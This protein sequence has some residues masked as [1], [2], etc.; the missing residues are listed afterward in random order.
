MVEE[1]GISLPPQAG[2]LRHWEVK[3]PKKLPDG[4]SG[5]LPQGI[6]TALC[7][8]TYVEALW[9]DTDGRL[10]LLPPT[11]GMLCPS[12][13]N[14]SSDLNPTGTK[15]SFSLALH[16]QRVMSGFSKNFSPSDT[17]RFGV[18]SPAQHRKTGSSTCRRSSKCAGQSCPISCPWDLCLLSWHT[19][20]TLSFQCQN[21]F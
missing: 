21:G 12:Q 8:P 2:K 9:L 17:Q 7:K 4:A 5:D 11:H 19:A 13:R 16:R 20:Q 6:V 10:M 3:W 18:C 15:G 14:L 1:G